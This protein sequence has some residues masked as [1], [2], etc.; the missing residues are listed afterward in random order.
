MNF[1]VTFFA[2]FFVVKQSYRLLSHVFYVEERGRRFRSH[3]QCCTRDSHQNIELQTKEVM[4]RSLFTPSL[5]HYLPTESRSQLC[6]QPELIQRDY[7]A[8][9]IWPNTTNAAFP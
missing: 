7:S 2:F 4:L 5:P 6:V 9:S 8:V 1:A 3:I